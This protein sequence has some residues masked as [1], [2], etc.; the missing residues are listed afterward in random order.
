MQNSAWQKLMT[1]PDQRFGKAMAAAI[2]PDDI[3]KSVYFELFGD[4]VMY[5]GAYNPENAKKLLDDLG[6][7]MGSDNFRTA[8]DGSEFILRITNHNAAPDWTP[9]VELLKEQIE[10]VGIHVDIDN[11]AGSLFEERKTTN[12][13]MAAI[14]W[15]DGPGWPSGISEDYLPNHKGPWSPMT[16]QYFTSNGDK[17]REPPADMQEFYK[18]H[19][20]RKKFPPE[21]EEGKKI[22]QQ[23]MQWVADHYVMIPTAGVRTTPT[24]VDARLRNVPNEGAPVDLDNIIVTEGYWFAQQ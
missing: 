6:M 20:E 21:S 8:P 12:D 17:G 15:N 5:D 16:W 14:H 3:N 24:L 2:N 22:F 1:D 4:P 10:A 11:V 18:L 13:I 7:K 23:L 19:T 9:V